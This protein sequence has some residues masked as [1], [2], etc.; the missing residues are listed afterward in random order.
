MVILKSFDGFIGKYI[1]NIF[2]SFYVYEHFGGNKNLL[3]NLCFI[4]FIENRQMSESH[5]KKTIWFSGSFGKE[6]LAKIYL[7]ERSSVSD[8]N[9]IVDVWINKVCDLI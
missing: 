4:Y 6:Y 2:C 5:L 8:L 7:L 9:I 3:L 1:L